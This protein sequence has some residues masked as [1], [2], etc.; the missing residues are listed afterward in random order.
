MSQLSAHP[1]A[2]IIL[3]LGALVFAGF[4]VLFLVAFDPVA[5]KLGITTGPTGRVDLVAT[6]VGFEV[7]F[8][9]FLAMCLFRDGWLE[10]GLLAS[11]FAFAGF[12]A[13]RGYALARHRGAARF[14]WLL[15]AA[16]VAGAA[17]SFGCARMLS[18]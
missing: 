13:A 14:L 17:L 5:S 2:W 10:A 16:E 11:G 9:G 12:G 8:A 18:A 3:A 6:Y 15:L 4:G 1:F 7:G